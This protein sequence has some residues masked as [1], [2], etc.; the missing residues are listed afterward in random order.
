MARTATP[1]DVRGSLYAVGARPEVGVTFVEPLLSQSMLVFVFCLT[2]RIHF[3]NLKNAPPQLNAGSLFFLQFSAN[4]SV[5]WPSLP[6]EMYIH[7]H[8][9]SHELVYMYCVAGKF[10]AGARLHV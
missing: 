2:G 5:M 6:I 1:S 3:F 10:L 4:A 9:N 7:V 8:A